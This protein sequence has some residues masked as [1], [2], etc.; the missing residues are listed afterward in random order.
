MRTL[1]ATLLLLA[2]LLL[3]TAIAA[4]PRPP[5]AVVLDTSSWA[6]TTLPSGR[7]QYQWSGNLAWQLS[8]DDPD[9]TNG[10]LTYT[11][12]LNVSINATGLT[13][14]TAT[15]T[16]G[17]CSGWLHVF[18]GTG[19]FTPCRFGWACVGVSY[20]GYTPALGDLFNGTMLSYNVTA[21]SATNQISAPSC[22]VNVDSLNITNATPSG[23]DQ[24]GYP[25][26]QPPSGASALITHAANST[27]GVLVDIRANL[28][29]DDTNQIQGAFRYVRF[30]YTDEYGVNATG[31]NLGDDPTGADDANG[32]RF[33]TLQIGG[34]APTD[35][36]VQWRA[37]EPFTRQWSNLSCVVNVD[38]K[39]NGDQDKC[40][41]L[42]L[43]K[44]SVYIPSGPTFPMFNATL[45][46][47][48]SG[49]TQDQATWLMVA[50]L[51]GLFTVAGFA[52]ARVPGALLMLALGIPFAYV[53]GLI[54][55]W[56]LILFFLLA[57]ATGVTLVKGGSTQ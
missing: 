55:Q 44:E 19:P 12:L 56:W 53:L 43:S 38:D 25:V 15:D 22:I 57:A 7:T 5:G 13:P 20:Q 2:L 39:I 4:T 42:G 18:N 46:Q 28:S 45:Y 36:H 17:Y 31:A 21:R 47:M 11:I 23:H 40:G 35:L 9:Q 24:C 29:S 3:P 52:V 30:L 16:T 54:P 26:I 8:P 48:N 33:D 50:A 10:S 37:I 27:D 1:P 51:T 32:Q 49:L 14:C 34:I 6:T 41:V